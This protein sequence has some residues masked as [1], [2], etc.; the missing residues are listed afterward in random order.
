M[1]K[2]SIHS[3]N[4][5]NHKDGF[6]CHIDEVKID[7]LSE[8]TASSIDV[9]CLPVKLASD[10]Y[11]YYT[12]NYDDLCGPWRTPQ[13]PAHQLY[14]STL[15]PRLCTWDFIASED[16][17][18]MKK[19]QT[20]KAQIVSFLE[21]KLCDIKFKDKSK[22]IFLGKFYNGGGFSFRKNCFS[23]KAV[24][25]L[26]GLVYL[27][28]RHFLQS[29]WIT[30]AEIY[31]FF[32]DGVLLHSVSEPP[33]KAEIFSPKE[34]NLSL[35]L[36]WSIYMQNLALLHVSCIPKYRLIFKLENPPVVLEKAT[37]QSVSLTGTEKKKKK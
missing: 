6:N 10:P 37:S 27:T 15:V 9:P 11:I 13:N 5:G 31:K 19:Y 35:K 21:T 14:D 30:A 16:I 26:L 23:G 34:C 17:S 20:D 33:K 22:R 7:S 29:P 1:T 3:K 2:Y 4:A 18:F 28:H 8:P 32:Y 24:S 25:A 36:F 12:V